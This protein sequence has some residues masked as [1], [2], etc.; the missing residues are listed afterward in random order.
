MKQQQQLQNKNKTR[1]QVFNIYSYIYEAIKYEL[2]GK[3]RF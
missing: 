2:K 3:K 1:H